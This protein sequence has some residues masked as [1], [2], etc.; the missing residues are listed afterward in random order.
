MFGEVIG[1][2]FTSLLPVEAK[3]FLLDATSHPVEVHV[4]CFGAFT[5]HVSG[6]DAVGG[7]VVSLGWSGRLR[8]AYFNQGRADMN[9]LF[10][11]EED[12]T[13]FS[14]GSRLNDGAD[15]LAPGEYRDVWS[16]IFAF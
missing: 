7:C 3:L 6:E 1:N 16:G 10:A 9:I 15:G 8:M 5:A 11:I 2:I 14:L 12:R 4:K 13:G